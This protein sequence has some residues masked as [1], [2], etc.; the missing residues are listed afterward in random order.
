MK[1]IIILV[2]VLIVIS[3]GIFLSMERED[4]ES[5][6]VR[7]GATL[8][9]SGDLSNF[10]VDAKNSIKLAVKEINAEGGINGK[11]V[12]IVYEDDMCDPKKCVNA[13]TKLLFIDNIKIILGPF[14]S[15]AALSVAP[16]TNEN[17]FLFIS[18][19]ATNP[20]LIDYPNFIRTI[21]SD[22]YQGAFAAEYIF[23]DMNIKYVAIQYAQNDY[24]I[25][26]KDAFKK[27]FQ[28]LGGEIVIEQA[29]EEGATDLRTQITRLKKTDAQLVYLASY[30]V[31]GGNF[32]K[33]A[34]E[35]ELNMEIFSPEVIEDEQFIKIGGLGTEGI[36]F[37]R[38]KEFNDTN[39][40]EKFANQYGNNPG[41][42]A[43]FYYDATM[44]LFDAID[45]C[46]FVDVGCV[47]DYFV[48]NEY[49][50]VSGSVLIDE[51]GN[52]IGQEFIVKTI[53]NGEFVPYNK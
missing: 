36:L 20:S 42:Y 30:P 8:P 1:K 4:R 37:T 25:G 14:C 52:R 39:F 33:Q 19:S 45:H 28:S 34:K 11:R 23:N 49:K 17:K 13:V 53:K 12:E 10:G 9:L 40:S 38:T 43:P 31:D 5:D 18:G 47:K 50:G 24:S 3:L 7:I 48:E 46:N 51:N 44:F 27:N 22:A 6:V 2:I 21:S 26:V 15:G 41:A 35:L 29:H 32:L 16:L